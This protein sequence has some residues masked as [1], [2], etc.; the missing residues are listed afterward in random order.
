AARRCYRKGPKPWSLPARGSPVRTFERTSLMPRPTRRDFL[1]TASVGALVT[2]AGTK[3]APRVLGA[4]E[5]IR[6][7]VAG[8]NSRGGSHV[9]AWTTIPGVQLTHLIDPDTRT[10]GKQLR[11]FCDQGSQPRCVQSVRKA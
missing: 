5:T 7:G 11:R 9:G 3:S 8:L 4:N 1:K 10:Y 2:I 6:I